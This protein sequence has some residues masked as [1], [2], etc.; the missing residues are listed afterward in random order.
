VKCR[1]RLGAARRKVTR[2]SRLA[3]LE[4]MTREAGG[5]DSTKDIENRL[6]AQELQEQVFQGIV[7]LKVQMIETEK[8]GPG[9]FGAGP[10][11]PHSPASL[12]L[13]SNKTAQEDKN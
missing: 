13:S 1:Y 3:R 8:F 11:R 7:A 10:T 9:V 6:S 2:H 4:A 12:H 5:T